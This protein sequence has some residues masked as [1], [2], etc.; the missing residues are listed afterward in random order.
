M[1]AGQYYDPRKVPQS[2][3]GSGWTLL[4]NPE[5]D[6]VHVWVRGLGPFDVYVTR[7]MADWWDIEIRDESRPVKKRLIKEQQASSRVAAFAKV[8]LWWF[9]QQEI[10]Q[11]MKKAS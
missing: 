3:P 2:Q 5:Q 7:H 6:R 10:S 11:P 4:T 8:N 9:S 1:A